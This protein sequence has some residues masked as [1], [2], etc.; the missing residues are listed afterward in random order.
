MK[1]ISIILFSLMFIMLSCS[2][3]DNSIISEIPT[4]YGKISKIDLNRIPVE[5]RELKLSELINDFQLNPLET[6]KECMISNTTIEFS[7]D[8]IF[9]GTQNFPGAA[10]LYRFDKKGT[11]INEIGKSG[12]GP[13]EHMGYLADVIHC[14]EG[15]NRVLVSWGGGP[16]EKPQLFNYAG[17]LIQEID[18]PF[19]HRY[20]DRWS[21]SVWFSPGAFAGK[22]MTNSDSVAIVFYNSNGNILKKIPRRLYPQKNLTEYTPSVGAPS[23]YKYSD[24]WRLFMEGNDTIF[25]IVDMNLIPVAI[26]VNTQDVLPYNKPVISDELPGK[27]SLEILAENSNN[28]YIDRTVIKKVDLRQFSPGQWGG[29]FTNDHQLLIIDKKSGKANL[30]RI[31]DDIFNLFPEE[32]FS[33][34]LKWQGDKI[35]FSVPPIFISKLLKERKINNVNNDS[36]RA[37]IEKL[38]TIPPDD[39]PVIF[40]FSLKDR[41]KIAD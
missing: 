40:I 25:K 30:F 7:R 34:I 22:P 39:N 1:L 35:F 27:Y 24:G 29:S 32:I 17:T 23:L 21:D 11:F 10:I 12:R 37:I 18:Q 13:G 15:S 38:E 3:R 41:V 14:Y 20:L 36:A 8:F 28:L 5:I 19:H 2:N 16:G 6:K 4:G 31:T 26:L 33:Q 9:V